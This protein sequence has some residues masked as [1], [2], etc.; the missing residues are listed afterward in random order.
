MPL[1]DNSNHSLSLT[2]VNCLEEILISLINK[3]LLRSWEEHIE[4]CNVPIDQVLVKAFLSESLGTCLVNLLSV[5]DQLLNPRPEVVLES[6]ENVF[7]EVHPCFMIESFICDWVNFGSQKLKMS[8]SFL[9][10]LAGVLHFDAWQPELEV[11]AE[12]E[13]ELHS[14]VSDVESS[15]EDEFPCVPEL[16]DPMDS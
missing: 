3:D 4:G 16:L 14:E 2:L 7:R 11:K 10:C 9:C 5:G 6:F 1:V 12:S 13:V 8:S 15:Q